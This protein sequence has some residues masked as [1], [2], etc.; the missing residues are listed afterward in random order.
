M[1]S[2]SRRRFLQQGTISLAGSI[3][4]RAAQRPLVST[5]LA[6]SHQ[7]HPFFSAAKKLDVIAHR[8]GNGH[9]PGETLYAMKRAVEIGVD[10]LEMDVYLTKDEKLVLMH[11]N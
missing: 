8:G 5:L 11:D 10:V 6:G 3:V 2:R 4:S 9:W 1:K 7:E